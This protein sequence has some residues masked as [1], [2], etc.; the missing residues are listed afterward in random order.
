[1]NMKNLNEHPEKGTRVILYFRNI[2]KNIDG[3]HDGVW[4]GQ[5]WM[6]RKPYTKDEFEPVSAHFELTGWEPLEREPYSK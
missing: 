6:F 2:E 3:N 1:M 4:T 5:E